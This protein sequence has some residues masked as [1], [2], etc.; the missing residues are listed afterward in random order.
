[1]KNKKLWWCLLVI[2]IMP[3][4]MP[5]ITFIYEMMISS[6]WT[7]A[8]WLILYSFVYWPTYVIGFII[9]IISVFQIRK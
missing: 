4:I 2:G 9:I 8:D 1:M 3:F 5:F 7:L 6:S